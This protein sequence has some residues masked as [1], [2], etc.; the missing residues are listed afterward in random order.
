MCESIIESNKDLERVQIYLDKILNLLDG[1]VDSFGYAYYASIKAKYLYVNGS[2]HE[3]KQ[4][5]Y[6]CLKVYDDL[7]ENFYKFETV[8][9]FARTMLKEDDSAE[10]LELLLKYDIEKTEVESSKLRMIYH[11]VCARAHEA[12]GDL[13]KAVTHYK[14]FIRY[15]GEDHEL[16]EMQIARIRRIIKEDEYRQ[17]VKKLHEEN[18]TDQLTKVYNRKKLLADIKEIFVDEENKHQN[19][20]ILMLDLD[21]FKQINDYNGHVAGDKCLQQVAR[22]LKEVCDVYG[23]ISYRYAGD[24]FFIIFTSAMPLDLFEIGEHLR[25]SI[26]NLGIYAEIEGKKNYVTASVGVLGFESERDARAR[27]II[28]EVDELMYKAKKSTKN[29]T[30]VKNNII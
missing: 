22:V 28:G 12:S 3:S 14:S 21:N 7:D 19:H 24:E 27:E 30:F 6:E 8:M 11:E 10:C 23:G 4:T 17:R 15:Q 9:A 18:I 29:A 16:R 13:A 2:Y 25:K 1:V 26:E 20:A 5:Y